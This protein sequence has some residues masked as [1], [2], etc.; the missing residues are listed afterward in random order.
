MDPLGVMRPS[1]TRRV[2]RGASSLAWLFAV[3]VMIAPFT[4]LEP[5]HVAPDAEVR[6]LLCEMATDG[7]Q[8]RPEKLHARGLAGL[9]EVLDWLLPESAAVKEADVSD[10]AIGEL[11]EQLGDDNFGIRE[12]ATQKLDHLR[13]AARGPLQE[14]TQSADA[15][16]G[17]RATRILRKWETERAA[18][19]SGYV[20]GF[21][22]Y[23]AGIDDDERLAELGKRCKTVLAEG[24]P[25][26]SKLAILHYCLAT[27]ARSG[28]EERCEAIRPLLTHEEVRVAVF[29]TRAMGSAE[30][31]TYPAIL[32]DALRDPRAEVVAAAIQAKANG[33]DSPHATKVKRALI[34]VFQR[35]D[36]SLKLLACAPLVRSFRYMPAVDYLLSQAGSEDRS[37]SMRAIVL[38]GDP[39][40]Q[41]E[42]ASAA[43]LRTLVP[44][45]NSS[46]RTLK[47]AAY[48][49][50]A[51]Y[52]GE[53][54]V[55]SLIPLLG[56]PSSTVRQEVAQ[57]LLAQRDQRML[58]RLLSTAAKDDPHK[59]VRQQSTVLLEGL[60][61]HG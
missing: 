32:L 52:A 2:P 12:A 22:A 51:T 7:A 10:D 58:R 34:S 16:I 54:V 33:A 44:L 46:D 53:E 57:K 42:P 3:G 36:D 15:E 26:D 48:S 18:D 45:L 59:Q 17:W 25:E 38:L 50:L 43:L 9:C 56:D 5:R 39:C 41:G 31:S 11:I 13:T 49:T 6:S 29:V 21:A 30:G 55:Q 20:A 37:R 35:N 40:H 61:R 28:N 19:K 14:A 1:R 47:R 4:P 23:V 24:M 8:F 27:V 60:D